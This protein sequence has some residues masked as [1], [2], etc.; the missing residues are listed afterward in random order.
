MIGDDQLLTVFN[1]FGS[2]LLGS[3]CSSLSV[4]LSLNHR[5]L[6]IILQFV[7]HACILKHS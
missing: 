2:A 7:L 5:S 1:F 6:V 4:F 3:L